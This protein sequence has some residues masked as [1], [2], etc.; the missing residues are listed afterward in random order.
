MIA[1]VMDS[2]I[3]MAMGVMMVKILMSLMISYSIS[4]ILKFFLWLAFHGRL[5]T[6]DNMTRKKW[7]QDAECDLCPAVESID[8]IALHCKFSNWVWDKWHLTDM[9]SQGT[10]IRQFV[11]DI[12]GIKQGVAAQAWPICFAACML[13]LSLRSS[14]LPRIEAL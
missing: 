9:A 6:K 2:M 4:E 13:N 12:Q 3:K 7:C 8:H 1:T 5:N 14:K 11:L 10:S